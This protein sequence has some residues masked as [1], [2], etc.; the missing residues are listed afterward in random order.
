MT[1]D[2]EDEYAF[3]V[4]KFQRPAYNLVKYY[5]GVREEEGE[6]EA[7]RMSK[8]CGLYGLEKILFGG[9]I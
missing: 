3:Y 1:E 4:R 2:E 6:A 5:E 8:K 9:T 7:V